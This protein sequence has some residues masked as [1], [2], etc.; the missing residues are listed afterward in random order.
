MKLRYLFDEV[1]MNPNDSQLN[2]AEF[3]NFMVNVMHRDKNDSEIITS[4]TSDKNMVVIFKMADL[5]ADKVVSFEETWN[6]WQG[7]KFG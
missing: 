4:M 3:R 5:D 7:T 6:F 1:D 2:A